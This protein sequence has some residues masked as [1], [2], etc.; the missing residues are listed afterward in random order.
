VSLQLENTKILFFL[1]TLSLHAKIKRNH[2]YMFQFSVIYYKI[3]E[4]AILRE[5]S[6]KKSKKTKHEGTATLNYNRLSLI[7]G[8]LPG[9]SK[10]TAEK[11]VFYSNVGQ[12]VGQHTSI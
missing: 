1:I 6:S 9:S 2:Y 5:K 11:Y 3:L 8:F 4:S 12:H 10:K 7:G